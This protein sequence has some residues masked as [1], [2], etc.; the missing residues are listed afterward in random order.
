M[1][2]KISMKCL[3]DLILNKSR[4]FIEWDYYSLVQYLGESAG[5]ELHYLEK[6]MRTDFKLTERE[7][8]K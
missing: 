1:L 7:S 2:S 8:K 6:N 4:G 5:K 3:Q